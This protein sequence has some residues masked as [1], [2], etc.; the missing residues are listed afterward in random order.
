[1][2]LIQADFCD[3]ERR[4]TSNSADEAFQRIFGFPSSVIRESAWRALRVATG[5]DGVHSQ[6]SAAGSKFYHEF[7]SEVRAF[8]DTVDE[9]SANCSDDNK[10]SPRAYRSDGLTLAFAQGSPATGNINKELHLKKVPG[11]V[12]L[13]ELQEKAPAKQRELSFDALT[14]MVPA[15]P[16]MWLVVYYREADL[17]RLEVSLPAGVDSNGKIIGWDKRLMLD[18]VNLTDQ[19]VEARNDERGEDGVAVAISAR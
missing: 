8:I 5:T 14:S 15:R 12:T 18:E 9:W 7:V 17:V 1:M 3:V 16:Q 6:L 19:F 2:G 11:T 10:T 4:S 13:L